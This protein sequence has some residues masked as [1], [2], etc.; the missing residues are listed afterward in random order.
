MAV[1]G[2]PLDPRSGGCNALIRE[3]AT[4]VRGIDDVIEAISRL[5]DQPNL[6]EPDQDWHKDD[7]T[8]ADAARETVLALLSVHPVGVDELRRLDLA[9]RLRR[10]PGGMVALIPEG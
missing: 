1:P 2:S 6:L 7:E 9:A 3:G 10:D 8:D 4:L 5:P